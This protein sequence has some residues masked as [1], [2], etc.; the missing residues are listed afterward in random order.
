M[1]HALSLPLLATVAVGVRPASADCYR[2]SAAIAAEA[3]TD[4]EATLRALVEDPACEAARVDLHYSLA[5]VLEHQASD[6]STVACDARA[7]YLQ[8][9]AAS[10]DDAVRA[11]ARAGAERLD[12]PC[13]SA[14]SRYAPV[15]REAAPFAEE[16]PAVEARPAAEPTTPSDPPAQLQPATA[17]PSVDSLP[18]L[19]GS[20]VSFAVGGTLLA[21]SVQT[22]AEREAA[23]KDYVAAHAAGRDAARDVAGQTYDTAG[24]RATW[25]NIGGW[26]AVGLGAGL[27]AV[28]AWRAFADPDGPTVTLRPGG[29]TFSV[30][31]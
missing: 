10:P 31:F 5:Y 29:A 4:A 2:A 19:I 11:D 13:A 17:E 23:G 18:W 28:A 25:L 21:L 14:R 8:V 12:A 1:K 3:W 26:G 22:D 24:E 27:C 15:D 20:A 7:L 9:A 16:T 6:G 30:A